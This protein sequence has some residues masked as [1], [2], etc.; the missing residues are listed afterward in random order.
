LRSEGPPQKPPVAPAARPIGRDYATPRLAVLS[1]RVARLREHLLRPA[2]VRARMSPLAVPSGSHVRVQLHQR[3]R[4]P[5]FMGE[6]RKCHLGTAGPLASFDANLGLRTRVP[7]KYRS[8]RSAVRVRLALLKEPAVNGAFFMSSRNRPVD[9]SRRL[10]A[11]P[12]DR[13]VPG[14]SVDRSAGDGDDGAASRW[15]AS[16][17][18]PW[19]AAPAP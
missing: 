8:R 7:A 5:G 15:V 9:T 18:P 12:A 11:L 4:V 1:N 3:R 17:S 19:R 14:S 16:R 6:N 13:D 2:R 10:P